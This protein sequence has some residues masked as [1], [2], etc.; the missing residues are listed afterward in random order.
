[1][2][3]TNVSSLRNILIIDTIIVSL[4]ALLANLQHI[5]LGICNQQI[6]ICLDIRANC[7]LDKN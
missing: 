1:M 6:R 2:I 5:T 7:E 3:G 4:S